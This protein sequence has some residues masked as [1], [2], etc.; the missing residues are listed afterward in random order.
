MQHVTRRFDLTWSHH[1]SSVLAQQRVQSR[2]QILGNLPE[3]T[4]WSYPAFKTIKGSC[5]APAELKISSKQQEAQKEEISSPGRTESSE[6]QIVNYETTDLP[7]YSLGL[8][9][10]SIN[11][12][13]IEGNEI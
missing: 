13:L 6:K 4:H 1:F 5:S 10:F 8:E 3:A 2:R 9:E 11:I 7:S 12:M